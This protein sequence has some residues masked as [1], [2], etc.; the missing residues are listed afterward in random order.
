MSGIYSCKIESVCL[1][2]KEINSV[3]TYGICL[4]CNKKYDFVSL[5][6]K[7]GKYYVNFS[8]TLN[9][10]DFE[11]CYRV[12]RGVVLEVVREQKLNDLGI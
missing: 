1:N 2:C 11:K 3:D 9:S 8:N 6:E 10:D 4:L 5:Y 12:P 7:N